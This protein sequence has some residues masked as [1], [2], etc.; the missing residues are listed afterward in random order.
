M[1]LMIV[2]SDEIYAIE[3]FYVKYLLEEGVKVNHFPAQRI[4]YNY[5]QRGAV[6]KILH[7]LGFSRIL[8]NINRQFKK[9]VESFNPEIIWVFK[10]MELF[11]ASLLWAKS[12]G[13]KLVNFNGD[14]PFVFSG[15]GSGNVNVSESITLYDLHFTYNMAI[16]TEMKKRRLPVTILPFGYDLDEILYE[17]C[18]KGKEILKL[19][20]LGNPDTFRVA[21]LSELAAAG[22]EMDLYGHGWSKFL[23]HKNVKIFGP[24]YA[25]EQWRTL[26]RYRVQ[27][28]MMRPHNPYSH[29]MRTFELG[30]VGAIQ[31]APDTA[32]HH[33][34]FTPG[35]DIFLYKDLTSCKAQ[36][37]YLL[38]LDKSDADL[39]RMNARKRS[40]QSGYGYH[41]RALLA[42][43]HL[44]KLV[45]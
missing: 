17:S 27:L 5:Y 35:K 34:Y 2:G 1:K 37:K 7:R 29:N 15:R 21:F 43:T 40:L 13:V 24:V 38:A 42:L 4:F 3:N 8:R 10:G 14:S 16:E 6:H 26:R 32:D 18:S 30:G 36:I 39:I 25:G 11:P 12:R 9:Q 22:I 44:L 33:L 28:N 23:Q 20:F 41:Q 31:L 19:C 45:E